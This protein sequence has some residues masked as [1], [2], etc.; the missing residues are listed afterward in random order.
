MKLALAALPAVRTALPAL[1]ATRRNRAGEAAYARVGLGLADPRDDLA[2]IIAARAGCG[3]VGVASR[4][5]ARRSIERAIG[6]FPFA[7]CAAPASTASAPPRAGGRVRGL[8]SGARRFVPSARDHRP[9]HN[10]RPNEEFRRKH[11]LSKSCSPPIHFQRQKRS[12]QGGKGSNQRGLRVQLKGG[13]AEGSTCSRIHSVSGAVVDPCTTMCVRLGTGVVT[14]SSRFRASR[15]LDAIVPS[16]A[17]MKSASQVPG[18]PRV[19]CRR[20]H[21]QIRCAKC[22]DKQIMTEWMS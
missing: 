15:S 1:V 22:A 11:L 10:H 9:N 19:P 6:S 7:A 16:G 2:A 14:P 17:S 18:V 8:R 20:E 12:V 5:D 21:R 13:E 4:L 3:D